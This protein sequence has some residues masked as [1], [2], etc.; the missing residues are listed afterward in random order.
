[1]W[2]LHVVVR[3]RQW[4]WHRHDV[5]LEASARDSN[6]DDRW[7]GGWEELFPNDAAG[8]FEGRQLPDH[9]IWWSTAWSVEAVTMSDEGASVRLVADTMAP[10]SFCAKE[11]TLDN[12]SATFAV[13]YRIESRE[14]NPFHF[15]FKQHLPV[16]VAPQCKLI[17][18]GGL[19]TPVDPAFGSLVSGGPPFPWPAVER[20]P[21][22]RV[23]LRDVTDPSRR[24]RE[25][26]Y[27]SG[28]TDGWCGVDDPRVGAS[29][30]LGYEASK[31]PFVWLFLTYGGWR[32]CFTAVLEP[33]TNMP[34]DLA[35]AVRLGQAARLP[36]GGMF[37]TR[38]TV[39]L[40]ALEHAN[41]E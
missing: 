39:R 25:F 2:E 20:S 28:L 37:E 27:V 11:F 13:S 4:I 16:A 38:A 5:A 29:L 17:L 32:D 3:K 19:V 33:C 8:E 26:V 21:G 23:D 12:D 14:R 18:P 35:T 7:A 24:E 36:A 15:L 10:A 6:Y 31:L 41:A 22:R 30:R 40:D 34:K 9:G 1:V